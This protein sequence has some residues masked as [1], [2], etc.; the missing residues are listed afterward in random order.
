MQ[1]PLPQKTIQNDQN[2]GAREKQNVVHHGS[3]AVLK[4]QKQGSWAVIAGGNRFFAD[5]S[6]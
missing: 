5:F 1:I 2:Q 6:L 4:G 3:D